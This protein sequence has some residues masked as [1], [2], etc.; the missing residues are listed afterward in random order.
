MQAAAIVLENQNNPIPPLLS[1]SSCAHLG[2][3]HLLAGVVDKAVGD[4]LALRV[5]DLDGI[6]LVEGSLDL[7]D[8]RGEQAG[9]LFEGACGAVVNPDLA[10]GGD[11][12]DPAL[13]TPEW[14]LFKDGE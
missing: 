10:L 8:A 5:Q 1:S 14:D 2:G 13:P 9:V 6:L 3:L 7:G 12:Q 11:A 4:G